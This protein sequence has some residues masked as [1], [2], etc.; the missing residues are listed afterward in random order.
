MKDQYPSRE[1]ESSSV[2]VLKW[3]EQALS[4]NG[5]FIDNTFGKNHYVDHHVTSA[6]F[7]EEGRGLEILPTRADAILLAPDDKVVLGHNA[8][9]FSAHAS[10]AEIFEDFGENDDP[11]LTQEQLLIAIGKTSHITRARIEKIVNLINALT[12]EEHRAEMYDDWMNHHMRWTYNVKNRNYSAEDLIKSLLR[13]VS[14]DE[15]FSNETTS[16]DVI[17]DWLKARGF[18]ELSEEI[19]ETKQRYPDADEYWFTFLAYAPKL[20]EKAIEEARQLAADPYIQPHLK[21]SLQAG[22]A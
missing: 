21:A 11:D 16:A 20:R 14:N 5:I 2:Q 4:V 7:Y 19:E 15:N 17:W 13:E 22:L 1:G 9:A 18:L 8:S 12:G 10:I 6:Y 3:S